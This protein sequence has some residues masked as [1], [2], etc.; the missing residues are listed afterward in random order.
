MLKGYGAHTTATGLSQRSN[1]PSG[2]S[3]CFPDLWPQTLLWLWGRPL[4]LLSPLSSLPCWA[5]STICHSGGDFILRHKTSP[6]VRW[7]CHRCGKCYVNG[8]GRRTVITRA[9]MTSILLFLLSCCLW[10]YYMTVSLLNLL[11]TH[12]PPPPPHPHPPARPVSP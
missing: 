2:R 4:C 11:N 3:R 10:K 7:K 9:S 12:S 1:V 5:W 6:T 8:R